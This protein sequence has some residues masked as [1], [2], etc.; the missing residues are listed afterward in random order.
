MCN[1]VCQLDYT[2][3]SGS[4][5]PVIWDSLAQHYLDQGRYVFERGLCLLS[6]AS[7]VCSLMCEC[8]EGEGGRGWVGGEGE[9][10]FIIALVTYFLLGYQSRCVCISCKYRK[11]A[12]A[13][14]DFN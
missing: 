8:G 2:D 3:G 5:V 13:V 1:T 4:G 10:P 6:A 9:I 7:E 11:T 12:K 14:N